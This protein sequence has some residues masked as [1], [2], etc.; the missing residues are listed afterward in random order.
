MLT[1][2]LTENQASADGGRRCEA[3]SQKNRERSPPSVNV[4]FPR[5][6]GNDRSR[7]LSG[8]GAYVADYDPHKKAPLHLSTNRIEPT[9]T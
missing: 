3:S 6:A 5:I 2:R 7:E 9:W 8:T 4:P 1:L